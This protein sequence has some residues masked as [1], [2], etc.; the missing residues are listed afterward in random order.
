MPHV[1]LWPATEVVGES[2]QVG[3]GSVP[4][5]LGVRDGCWLR[6]NWMACV[7]ACMCSQGRSHLKCVNDV[8]PVFARATQLRNQA[9]YT[10]H[11]VGTVGDSRLHTVGVLHVSIAQILEADVVE[12]TVAELAEMFCGE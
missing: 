7:R 10:V 2:E 1:L 9:G 5:G 12:E 6:A 4:C 3:A 11:A 8:V